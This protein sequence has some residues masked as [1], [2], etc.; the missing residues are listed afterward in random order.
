MFESFSS[1]IVLTIGVLTIRVLT[2]LLVAVVL[3]ALT[4][5]LAILLVVLAWLTIVIGHL[6]C[7]VGVRLV[8]ALAVTSHSH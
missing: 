2:V 7:L 8:I 6:W 3:I 5:L 4:G 1:P